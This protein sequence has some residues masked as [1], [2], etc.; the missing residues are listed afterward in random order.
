MR[1]FKYIL[2]AVL[3]AALLA[4]PAMAD[5]EKNG[6]IIVVIDPGHGGVDGGSDKGSVPE[7]Y[8]NMK[9]S[10]YLRDALESTGLFEVH[11]TRE[12]DVYLKYLPRVLVAKEAGADLIISMHCNTVYESWVS[13]SSAYVTLIEDYAAWDVAN[14]LLDHLGSATSIPRGQVYTRADT[15]DSLGVY[16]WDYE[17][18]WDMPGAWWL[19]KVSD[20]YSISTFSSKFGIPSVIIEHGYLS[21]WS[22]LA[23]LDNDDNLRKMAQ[24]EADALIEYYTN[25]EHM[26]GDY[27]VDFPS[28]CTFTGT[29]SRRCTICGAR[30]GIRALESAP[31]NH[32]WRQSGSAKLS[33][34]TDGYI[35][36]VCQISYNANDKGYPCTVHQYSNVEKAPGHDYTILEDTEPTH[37]K[38]GKLHKV[39]R[40]CGHEILEIRAGEG[41][42]WELSETVDPTCE[43]DGEERYICTVC[44]ETKVEVIP[45]FGHEFDVIS[46]T[47]A[48]HTDD[49]LFLQ[50]CK[51][52]GKEEKEVREAEGHLFDETV[53]VV[54]PDCVA[55][56]KYFKT[57]T[58]CG[59]AIE[60]VIAPVGHKEVFSEDGRESHCSVC[61]VILY[62]APL[63]F[64]ENPVF[65]IVIVGI[66]LISGGGVAFIL[67]KTKKD[68]KFVNVS[69]PA[70]TEIDDEDDDEYMDEEDEMPHPAEEIPVEYV[71]SPSKE[72]TEDI[73]NTEETEKTEEPTEEKQA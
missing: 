51:T 62:E 14:L 12:T 43:T 61:G 69:I 19:G 30:S 2:M 31:D 29:E 20:Y 8:Y 44:P 33:C 64:Y 52:C 45:A 53:A 59:E 60:E 39:C 70:T 48:T 13:G 73:E 27:E 3:M 63:P 58:V 34:E 5:I 26:F 38:D 71:D 46:D 25:H 23:V 47:E 32:F 65:Y 10:E 42:N 49:G 6:K 28:N 7:K 40:T 37:D 24:A 9:L 17:K 15:G 35:T 18:Q 21:N 50:I 1:I 68:R 16:Y 54:S 55:E 22:D 4:L 72:D 36:Y 11:M 56:V 66:L 41:H 67:F 57:C